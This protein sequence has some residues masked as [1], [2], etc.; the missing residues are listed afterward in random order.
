M[1]A[2]LV[3]LV[4]LGVLVVLAVRGERLRERVRRL[5]RD[6][7]ELS[8]TLAAVQGWAAKE[9]GAV[10]GEFT[11]ARV[12]ASAADVLARSA[13]RTKRRVASAAPSSPVLKLDEEGEATNVIDL[14]VYARQ[15]TM[16]PPAAPLAHPDLI[17]CEDIADEAAR[18]RLGPEDKTPPRRGR[19][20][21]V[22][23][24]SVGP[25]E[26]GAA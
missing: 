5:E 16:R 7:A 17:G 25:K 21:M 4:G 9:I 26:G 14:P 19:A 15:E 1:E 23:P 6:G 8:R 11:V 2:V 24:L 20:S 3:G 13:D 10:R 12:N 22:V 18:Q